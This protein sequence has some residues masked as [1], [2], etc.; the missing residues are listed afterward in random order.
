MLIAHDFQ[1]TFTIIFIWIPYLQFI[2][3]CYDLN[4]LLGLIEC[5]LFILYSFVAIKKII[6]HYN[7]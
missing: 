2:I 7:I 1:D 3:V 6:I 5:D 4:L